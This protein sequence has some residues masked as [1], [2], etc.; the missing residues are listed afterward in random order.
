MEEK[1]LIKISVRNLVEFILRE[2]DIDNRTGGADKDA[3]QQGSRIH[4]KIQRRMGS[5]YRA[6][7]SLK[8]QVPCEGFILQVEGR[9]DGIIED[10]KGVMIDEIK[11]VLKELI[12]IAEPS[13]LHLAQAKCYA[14]FYGSQNGLKNIRVQMT[15][16]NM[17]TEE[18][19]QFVQ[20]FTINEL[21]E[22]FL[23]LIRQYE[24]WASF[25]IEWR[26][27]RNALVKA[28]EFPFEYRA[29]QRDIVASVYRTISRKKKLFIQ[30][31]TGV[32][33]TMAS[34]FPAVKAIGEDLGE[35]IFYLTAKTI[36]R[37][38]AE[39]A[40]LTLKEQGLEFKVITL[41]AKDKICFCEEAVCNPEYC[42]YAKGH[43]NRVNDAVFDMI[44]HTDDMSRTSLEIHAKAHNVCPF[45]MA[46]DV[47]LWVDAIICD[48]NYVFDPNAHLKRFFSEGNKGGYLFLIDEAHNLV[49][50]GREMYSAVLYKE[51]ILEM[52]RLVKSD[53]PELA[54]RLEECNKQLLALKK[55]CETYQ[56]LDGISHIALKL[57]NI[58]TGLE[59]YLEE[60]Q[61]EEKKNKYWIFIFRSEIS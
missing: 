26:K 6:E 54:G 42:P 37:T 17:E 56:V 29:G 18:L 45:E 58:M 49:E 60:V 5:N 61:G 30:A 15:Y 14:Y 57:M 53:N 2:G 10:D 13:N 27:K 21:E 8:T 59:E 36:T 38:V 19:K 7:V 11:G 43:Y 52:K 16:C 25:Q 24:K 34:V 50:R 31:P 20:V 32:G 39:Q 41:T 3:M 23:E 4:C 22:W 48:Y 55:E 46:L 28:T 12:H 35:R 51:A 40:F 44:T 1:E 9:A 47:S 33:K